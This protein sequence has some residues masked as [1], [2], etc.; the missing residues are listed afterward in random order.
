MARRAPEEHPEVAYYY[1]EP[2]WSEAE[3]DR[4]KS[5]LLFFD[6]IAILL[7]R[8]MRGRE[9]LADPAIAGAMLDQG[10][11]MVLEPESFIDSQ[12]AKD[13]TSI[14]LEL[15]GAGAFDDLHVP[16]DYQEL[17][18]SRAG[19]VW[20]E[21]DEVSDELLNELKHRRL[22]F[23]SDDGVSVPVHPEVRKTIL[24]LLSQLARSAGERRGISL[25]PTTLAM[26]DR[27]WNSAGING[28]IS[29]AALPTMPSMG[30]VVAGQA[31]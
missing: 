16:N 18:M 1:P 13:L 19:R 21:Q 5:L 15:L 9:R 8:Y 20:G 7:P 24:I 17:S 27:Y 22:A 28:L 11:L 2:Y 23:E 14:M 4:L 30:Q 3:G 10:L 29:V 31:R 6:Q 25:N 26:E 12:M